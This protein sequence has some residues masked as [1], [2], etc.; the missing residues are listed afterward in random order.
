MPVR[1]LKFRVD[2]QTIA[3]HSI[4]DGQQTS[5]TVC[6]HVY[7]KRFRRHWSRSQQK[8]PKCSKTCVKNSVVPESFFFLG[9]PGF[10]FSE[11][12]KLAP[13]PPF[14]FFVRC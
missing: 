7:L 2:L 1:K 3:I 6:N 4:A 8:A 14:Y 13:V 11:K 5:V 12:R 9:F 10:D